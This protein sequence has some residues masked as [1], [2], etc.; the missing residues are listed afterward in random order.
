MLGTGA[1]LQEM[2]ARAPQ[3]QHSQ[4]STIHLLLPPSADATLG[5]RAGQVGR[6]RPGRVVF[7]KAPEER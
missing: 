5:V 7:I 2:I 3:T 1:G 4:T 6:P